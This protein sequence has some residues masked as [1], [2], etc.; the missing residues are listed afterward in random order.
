[1]N[2]FQELGMRIWEKD[3]YC[4]PYTNQGKTVVTLLK[5]TAVQ[6]G[7]HLIL[8]RIV[9]SIKKEKEGF[10]IITSYKE[11]D[12]DYVVLAT[13]GKAG[14]GKNEEAEGYDLARAFS[15]HITPLIS[16]LT[17]VFCGGNYSKEWKGIRQ[18]AKVYIEVDGVCQFED[19]GEIQ[20]NEDNVSGKRQS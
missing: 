20:F 11:F 17:K 13:G 16:G 2:Y 4:Y 14:I 5:E 3:G 6:Y 19:Y 12:A 18:K 1:M 10:H 15:H 7:V 8:D 9:Q